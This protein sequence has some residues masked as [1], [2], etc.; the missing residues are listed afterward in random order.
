MEALLSLRQ[1]F[2]VISTLVLWAA[3]IWIQMQQAVV[4]PPSPPGPVMK[5]VL[6]EP[7]PPPPM[8]TP[9]T[10]TP[11]QPTQRAPV[12]PT[13]PKNPRP[14]PIAQAPQPYATPGPVSPVAEPAPP[15]P[16]APPAV[17]SKQMEDAYTA[18]IKTRIE[19]EKKYP[20]SKDAR[21]Q[22]PAGTV[23][24]IFVLARTGSLVSVEVS[25]SAGSILD[26]QA[27]A[28]VKR[29]VYPPFPEE[30]WAGEAQRQFHTELDFKPV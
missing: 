17:S 8:P 20:T 16:P 2:A 9:P 11:P 7:S 24:L 29:G 3:L 25:E 6:S 23:G 28:T 26:K 4:L 5:V 15:S 13:A 22:R 10:P 14:E 12:T 1:P 18:S 19:Q 21:L 27:I 30:A